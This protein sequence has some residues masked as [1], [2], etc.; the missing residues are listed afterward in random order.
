MIDQLIERGV[1]YIAAFYLRVVKYL[2]RDD[3]Y[4]TTVISTNGLT[5]TPK[6][7]IFSN[8]MAGYQM[9]KHSLSRDRKTYARIDI[10]QLKFVTKVVLKTR[11]RYVDSKEDGN[12]SNQ[13]LLDRAESDMQNYLVCLIRTMRMGRY[14]PGF[15]ILAVLPTN[16]IDKAIELINVGV[17]TTTPIRTLYFYK[18]TGKTKSFYYN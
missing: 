6:N 8:V 10:K 15:S 17:T 2:G 16:D 14:F 5:Q 13:V 1:R 7:F 3:V 11:L 12:F 18:L 9:V 4:Y